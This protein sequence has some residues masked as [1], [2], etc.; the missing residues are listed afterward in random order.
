VEN[1]VEIAKRLPSTNLVKSMYSSLIGSYVNGLERP[2][3]SS[4]DKLKMIIAI[5]GSVTPVISHGA[6]AAAIL[7][8]LAL[9]ASPDNSSI[10]PSIK[11]ALP[12]CVK[13]LCGFIRALATGIAVS[14]DGCALLRALLS[15]DVNHC[16]WTTNHE[17]YKARLMFQCVTMHAACRLTDDDHDSLERSLAEMKH[18]LLSWC[19]TGYGPR[20]NGRV[21]RKRT[22]VESATGEKIPASDYHSV[23]NSSGN[24]VVPTWLNTMRCVLFLEDADSQLMRQFVAPDIAHAD[25]DSEWHAERER[26]RACCGLGRSVNDEMIWTVVRSCASPDNGLLPDIAI[27]LLEN[28]FENCGKD[29]MRSLSVANPALVGELYTLAQFTPPISCHGYEPPAWGEVPRLALSH[30]WW[31]VTAL[32]LIMCAASAECI[33]SVI[34]RENP[35]LRSIM[36]MVTSNRF[37]FPTVDCD[38]TARHEV[39]TAEQRAR[40]QET[41]IAERLFLQPGKNREKE[42]IKR[43]GARASTRLL[44]KE[45]H[46]RSLR[47]QDEK[48]RRNALLKTA[49]KTIMIY[50]YGT[51][52]R[53]PP[54]EAADI[55]LSIEH[56]FNIS[57]HFQ[58]S[59]EPDF[60]LLTIGGTS[61]EAIERAYDWLLPIISKVPSTIG[62]LPSSASCFLLLR[63]NANNGGQ[64]RAQ[65]RALS[66]PLLLHVIKCIHGELGSAEAIK[67]LDL[68]LNDMASQL[69]E[70]RRCARRV[71]QATLV[72]EGSSPVYQIRPDS[73]LLAILGLQHVEL[74]VQNTIK[75]VVCI[76]NVPKALAYNDKVLCHI[77]HRFFLLRRLQLPMK[78]G[79]TW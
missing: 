19:C 27:Q 76:G 36:K 37:R 55:L 68:L 22:Y 50:D 64:D 34:W 75:F 61:R 1:I 30:L 35:T 15:F 49:Q 79:R 17:E 28:M 31:R 73:W 78:E 8:M 11:T 59:A 66:S 6:I 45:A 4:T 7:Q 9:E 24:Q 67:A 40:D 63:A 21:R 72:H 41:L 77:S 48:K 25:C 5:H 38:D 39:K 54:R 33:G 56:T 32:A 29:R 16:N 20:F 42:E 57:E 14:F 62:R 26:I 74:V 65:L 69:P 23:L 71:L 2:D 46:A 44:K 13:R 10:L 12:E 53:K 43:A 18:M 60:L 51:T 70:R 58:L 3:S 52:A 47:E